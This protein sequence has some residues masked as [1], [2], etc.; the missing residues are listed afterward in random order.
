M[1]AVHVRHGFL[2][3]VDLVRLWPAA[4]GS[5][6]ISLQRLRPRR[7]PGTFGLPLGGLGKG[8]IIER[9]RVDTKP[10]PVVYCQ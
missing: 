3:G 6:N 7:L 1:V 5:S 4:A 9:Q 8:V 2:L 10:Q